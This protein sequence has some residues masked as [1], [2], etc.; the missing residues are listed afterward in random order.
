MAEMKWMDNISQDSFKIT[1]T[2]CGCTIRWAHN[3]RACR[4]FRGS[5]SKKRAKSYIKW[6]V[7]YLNSG[8]EE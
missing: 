6:I 4:T 3:N 2:R 7:D 1:E 5:D 8:K